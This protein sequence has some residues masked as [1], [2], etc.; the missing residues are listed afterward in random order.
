MAIGAAHEVHAETPPHGPFDLT[1]VATSA[2]LAKMAD[3]AP[4]G[5]ADKVKAAALALQQV[6]GM[7]LAVTIQKDVDFQLGFNAKDA[8]TAADIA[9]KGNLGLGF[10]KN[11]VAEQAKKDERLVP[12][13]DVLN[14][15]RLT[16]AGSNLM[17][18]GQVSYETLGKLL[19]NLPL[20]KQ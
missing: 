3:N 7:S 6:D 9:V 11:T 10:A 12:A 15:I 18:R 19:A 14:T 4:E 8:K 2:V 5:A 1:F 16:S 13:V 20:P 17:I